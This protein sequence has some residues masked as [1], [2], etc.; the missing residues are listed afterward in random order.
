MV[1]E[2]CP[3]EFYYGGINYTCLL[4]TNSQKASITSI[5]IL[6]SRPRALH[7]V[8]HMK[9]LEQWFSTWGLVTPGVSDVIL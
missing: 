7:S 4:G 8:G 5:T 3:L 2:H 6:D 9:G 1:E